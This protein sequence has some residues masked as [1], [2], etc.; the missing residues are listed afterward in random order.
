MGRVERRGYS[1][2]RQSLNAR[3]NKVVPAAGLHGARRSQSK[4]EFLHT[5]YAT[6]CDMD[7]RGV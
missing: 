5:P 6:S 3:S 7:V 1:T 4:A 2:I